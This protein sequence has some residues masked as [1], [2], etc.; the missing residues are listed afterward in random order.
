[1]SWPERTS[2]LLIGQNAGPVGLRTQGFLVL[3]PQ[4]SGFVSVGLSR[5]L[6]SINLSISWLLFP[7]FPPHHLFVLV[8]PVHVHDFPSNV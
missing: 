6:P 1:M 2:S 3:A 5:T 7:Y 8:S 4:L